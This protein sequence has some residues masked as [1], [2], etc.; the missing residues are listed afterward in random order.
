M[1]VM[2]K[3]LLK[4]YSGQV[5]GLVYY[6]D[7]RLQKVICRR[8]VIPRETAQNRNLSAVSKH[9]KELEPS[10]GYISD[11]KLYAAL[12]RE[13]GMVLNW[14]NVYLKMM[15]GLSREHGI[16]LLELTRDDIYAQNLPVRSLRLA[17]EAGLLAPVVGYLRLDSEF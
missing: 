3:N 10:E 14:R 12:S 5:D 11:L 13:R 9:L 7:P 8:H 17:V 16:N 4:A 15:Y 1:K 6:Y 2:F